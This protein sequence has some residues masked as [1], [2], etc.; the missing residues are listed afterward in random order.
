MQMPC[1]AKRKTR[2]S[3]ACAFVV[4]NI[5]HPHSLVLTLLCC[6]AAAGLSPQQT[7]MRLVAW[8]LCRYSLHVMPTAQP[9]SV[10]LIQG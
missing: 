9:V 4:L 5:R 7:T 6:A 8:L 3:H 1:D 10:P 2:H